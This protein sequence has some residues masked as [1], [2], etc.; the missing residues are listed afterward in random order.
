MKGLL[1]TLQPFLG[2]YDKHLSYVYLVFFCIPA[3]I[4]NVLALQ[5]KYNLF[6]LIL[7]YTKYRPSSLIVQFSNPLASWFIG[8]LIIFLIGV[9]FA[10]N[11][12]TQDTQINVEGYTVL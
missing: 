11:L 10:Q 5:N 2:L 12:S 8:V 6:I 9:N 1:K 4:I 7:Q 3:K